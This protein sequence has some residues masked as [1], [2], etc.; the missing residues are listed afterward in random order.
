MAD[1]SGS[2]QLRSAASRIEQQALQQFHDRLDGFHLPPAESLSEGEAKSVLVRS[3]T[4][5]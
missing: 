3:M 1:Q 5:Q 2:E 4:G